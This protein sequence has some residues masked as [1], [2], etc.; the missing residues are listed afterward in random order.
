M[1]ITLLMLSGSGSFV[2]LFV[3]NLRVLTIVIQIQELNYRITINLASDARSAVESLRWM[4]VRRAAITIALSALMILATLQYSTYLSRLD[5]VEYSATK[6][7]SVNERE[8]SSASS[9]TS[10]RVSEKLGDDQSA[11][12]A[13]S[14]STATEEGSPSV[15][16]K[17]GYVS[18]G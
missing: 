5:A 2:F 11:S 15:A 3:N 14:I 1:L 7:N 9:N 10:D 6:G 17:S 4:L 18:L 8:K 16:V 12:T 13:D